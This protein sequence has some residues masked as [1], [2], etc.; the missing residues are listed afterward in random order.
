MK[1][2]LFIV[3]STVI[4]LII[5]KFFFGLYQDKVKS[6]NSQENI[7]E[8]D[9]KRPEN[10]MLIECKKSNNF[11]YDMQVIL[12]TKDNSQEYY[13]VIYRLRMT[14]KISNIYKDI[15]VTAFL[16]ES[17][18]NIFVMQDFLGFGTDIKNKQIIDGIKIK[19][20]RSSKS[21][22]CK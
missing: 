14:P 2:S 9:K 5:S 21:N 6:I 18:K 11:I 16:D 10:L 8:Y 22:I 15:T 13:R 12:D 3:L 1:K 20:N 7:I 4:L 17:M 19:R